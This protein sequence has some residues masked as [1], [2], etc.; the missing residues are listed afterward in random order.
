MF[1]FETKRKKQPYARTQFL[2]TETDQNRPLRTM[3]SL[4]A[5]PAIGYERTIGA[6]HLAG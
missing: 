2:L 6:S 5:V 3:V 1:T 4:F